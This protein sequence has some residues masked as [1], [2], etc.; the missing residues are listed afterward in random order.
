MAGNK[1]G[2]PKMLEMYSPG[3]EKHFWYLKWY[4]TYISLL[5]KSGWSGSIEPKKWTKK[6]FSK[7]FSAVNPL[8]KNIKKL[9]F[10]LKIW[11]IFF[12]KNKT[13][14][15]PLTH[16]HDCL[17]K[18]YICEKLWNFEKNIFLKFFEI[19]IE[20]KT[21]FSQ[22]KWCRNFCQKLNFFL[23]NNTFRSRL[24]HTLVSWKNIK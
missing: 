22:K 20:K 9:F 3:H 7:N 8:K 12:S 24:I 17:K 1:I 16:K 10:S 2:H 15:S 5:K 18:Y 13:L 19:V 11:S 23:K 14:R 6:F 4:H 21:L